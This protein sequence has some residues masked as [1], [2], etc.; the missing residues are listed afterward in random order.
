MFDIIDTFYP[1]I[2]ASLQL[3]LAVYILR[4]K[5]YRPFPFFFAYTL[6][7]VIATVARQAVTGRALAYWVISWGTEA[8]Y[9]IL[10]LASISEAF[11]R[12]FFSFYRT[13][14]W[15]RLVLPGIII[16]IV[17]I[18]AWSAIQYPLSLPRIPT[19]IYN[20]HLGIHF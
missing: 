20:F 14:R 6:F 7:S 13:F 17:A 16:L 19:V 9:G 11:K 3:V 5:H 15:F 10:A 8:V 4:R 18:T 2:P 1:W 12:I